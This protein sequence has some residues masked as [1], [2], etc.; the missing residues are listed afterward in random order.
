[1][2]VGKRLGFELLQG[3]FHLCLVQFHARLL[4]WVFTLGLSWSRAAH[5]QHCARRLLAWEMRQAAAF[6]RSSHQR[7]VLACKFASIR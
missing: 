7:R 4:T 6:D 1:M 2:I 5:G 3:A